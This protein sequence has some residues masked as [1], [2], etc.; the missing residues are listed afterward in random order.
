MTM[1]SLTVPLHP[2]ET[3]TSFCSRLAFRNGCDANSFCLDMGFK[4]LAVATG[5]EKALAKL[6]AFSGADPYTLR[7]NSFT[8]QEGHGFQ[9]RGQM[10]NVASSLRTHV[11]V[12]PDCISED[13]AAQFDQRRSA[14]FQRIFWQLSWFRSCPVHGVAL[15]TLGR[16][17][18]TNMIE[19]ADFVKAV[20][21]HVGRIVAGDIDRVV[22][23]PSSIELYLY[24]RLNGEEASTSPWLD[25]IPMQ[26]AVRLCEIVGAVSRFGP[27]VAVRDL[28]EEAVLEV[29]SIGCDILLGGE[30]SFREFVRRAMS[31]FW[32][33]SGEPG[34]RRYFGLLYE[35]LMEEREERTLDP[36]R[37][38]IREEM[39][40]VLPVA[41]SHTVFDVPIGYRRCWSVT[42]IATDL[43]ITSSRM[44]QYF[45][46]RGL[47]TAEHEGLSNDRITFPVAQIEPLVDQLRSMV[48]QKEAV[49]YFG[50]P[51]C[52]FLALMREGLIVPFFSRL[53]AGFFCNG[54]LKADLDG[55][56][57]KLSKSVTMPVA[58]EG[59]VEV[60]EAARRCRAPYAHLM[61]ILLDGTLSRVA[62]WHGEGGRCSLA[63]DPVEVR[64]VLAK[65]V[66]GEDQAAWPYLS[67]EQVREQTRW[68]NG[69]TWTLISK[70][71]LPHQVMANPV[72][73]R[74]CAFVHRD[75]LAS[76]RRKYVTFG[77][78]ARE[79]G[80]G[81]VREI[82]RQG[83]VRPVIKPGVGEVAFYLRSDFK[84]S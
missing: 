30:D 82:L 24:R 69:A 34:V 58:E 1:L 46:A 45:A 8:S 3:P 14:P 66:P 77:E 41:A 78:A 73:T 65:Q 56:L 19:C 21:P 32:K 2:D 54:F 51:T 33:D 44:R 20:A 81:Y 9:L 57:E 11:R 59:M 29:E 42:T 49:A 76:F 13:V 67:V 72:T 50:I 38:A 63:V 75:E 15:L 18:K 74:K 31:A 84:V 48:T 80:T 28:D 70:G 23:A 35:W 7:R 5:E 83:R 53:E 25:S 52:R 68:G 64:Q 60:F 79:M 4:F 36:V 17:K 22:R 43:T 55:F 27:K 47:I 40:E 39:A 12:C 61:R 16:A 10:V 71:I 37:S 26:K 62:P 6:A